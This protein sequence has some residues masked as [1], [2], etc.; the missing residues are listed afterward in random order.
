MDHRESA[1]GHTLDEAKQQPRRDQS[2][3]GVTCKRWIIGGI[4]AG[5]LLIGMALYWLQARNFQSTDDAYTTT[6]VH[7]ISARVAGYVATVN[8]DADEAVEHFGW[9]GHFVA[10]DNPTSSQRTRELLGWQSKQPGLIHD[11]DRLSSF[12]T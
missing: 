5:V 4:I 6:H 10:I 8:L 1:N 12:A 3:R 9:L 11:I 2:H 7:D